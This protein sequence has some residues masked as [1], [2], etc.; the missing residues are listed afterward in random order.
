MLALSAFYAI[1]PS[2]HAPTVYLNPEEIKTIAL[3][4]IHPYM[5]CL[6]EQSWLVWIR[7]SF[8]AHF[9]ALNSSANSFSVRVY[10]GLDEDDLRSRAPWLRFPVESEVSDLSTFIAFTGDSNPPDYSEIH[11][12]S[13][14][15]LPGPY[16][17]CVALLP[18]RSHVQHHS[19]FEVAFISALDGGR[20]L[21]LL[22]GLAI[23]FCAP[24]FCGNIIFYY[25]SGISISILASFLILLFLVFRLL[26]KRSSLVLQGLV[27]FGGGAMSMLLFC[28][29]HLRIAFA[30]FI[31]ANLSLFIAYALVVALF[32][33]A[34]LYWFSL[35]E[36]LLERFPR[37]ENLLNL[38]LRAMGVALITSAPQLPKEFHRVRQLLHEGN[39][40]V[41]E[42][43]R[44]DCDE[45]ISPFVPPAYVTTR[46]LF[47]LFVTLVLQ[48]VIYF[49]RSSDRRTERGKFSSGRHRRQKWYEDNILPPVPCAASS[50]ASPGWHP[51]YTPVSYYND[52]KDDEEEEEYRLPQNGLHRSWKSPHVYMPTPLRQPYYPESFDGQRMV[53]PIL[54]SKSPYA[55]YSSTHNR[56]SYYRSR[57][58]PRV[59]ACTELLTDDDED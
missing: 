54:P 49:L 40:W 59:A 7:R 30:N 34:I 35:P 2:S 51:A 47:A 41:E 36:T 42:K 10:Y 31:S 12:N 17:Q 14:V 39:R 58:S 5:V 11:S 48:T 23:Y 33:T 50:P 4:P 28:L 37:T 16:W 52:G 55:G 21:R 44:V 9:L 15:P 8:Q 57:A 24:C 18:L 22:L 56:N 25:C 53:S 27:V 1:G 6:H 3:T 46:L 26:P 45:L 20:I 32:S 43:F 13:H 38:C 19:V 29:D